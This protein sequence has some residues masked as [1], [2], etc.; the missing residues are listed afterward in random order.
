A[1]DEAGALPQAIDQ[2]H[3]ALALG[4][5]FH[6]LRYKLGRMLLHAGRAL[7]AREHFEIIVRARPTYLDAAAMLGLAC[8]LARARLGG[9]PAGDY[10]TAL[11]EYQLVLKAHPGSADLSAKAGAAA[12][13]TGEYALAVAQYVA[14]G[15][16]DRSRAAEAADGLERLVRA[17]LTGNDRNA[18]ANALQGL[19]TVS[20]SRPL[21]RYTRLA[22]LDAA[23]RGDTGAALALLPSAV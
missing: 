23:E 14:L 17:A 4:P 2:Y 1:Y 7:D 6:D 19:R 15:Q 21:G 3:A 5:A 22:A 9:T 11:A 16:E 20:P 18:A 8:S 12:L 10:R 13:H